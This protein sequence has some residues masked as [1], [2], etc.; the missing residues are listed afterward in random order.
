MPTPPP[1]DVSPPFDPWRDITTFLKQ[2]VDQNRTI[3]EKAVTALDSSAAT[4]ADLVRAMSDAVTGLSGAVEA[5]AEQTAAIKAQTETFTL[6][7]ADVLELKKARERE[8][9]ATTVRKGE[10]VWKSA[11]W[12]LAT[13][14][15]LVL[16]GLIGA[17][18]KG[19]EA[20]ALPSATTERGIEWQL[21]ASRQ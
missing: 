18:F 10:V 7:K 3:A 17:S 13:G 16:A 4:N 15:G 21:N 5:M 12:L 8:I 20:N 14:V 11:G 6:L 1:S 2:V 9:E 19:C